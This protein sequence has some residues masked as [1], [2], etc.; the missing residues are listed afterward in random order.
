MLVFYDI[1][2]SSRTCRNNQNLSYNRFLA[3]F[4]LGFFAISPPILMTLFG[5]LTLM[6]IRTRRRRVV[7]INVRQTRQTDFQLFRMLLCQVTF[8]IILVS[9]FNAMYAASTI[10]GQTS[11][12]FNFIYKISRLFYFLSYS[13]SFYIYTLSA[14]L[15]RKEF[16]K[17]VNTVLRRLFK[18]ET[19]QQPRQKNSTTNQAIFAVVIS[20]RPN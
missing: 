8:Y 7:P 11:S 17:I 12:L 1:D 15:Y 4:S 20:V 16:L 5:L 10:L 13:T 3:F 9:P 18:I 14:R 2:I 19:N 6:N